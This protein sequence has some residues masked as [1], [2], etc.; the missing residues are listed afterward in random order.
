M[1]DACCENEASLFGA[2]VECRVGEASFHLTRY[3][4]LDP[5]FEV[6][7]WVSEITPNRPVLSMLAY[8][9]AS[10]TNCMKATVLDG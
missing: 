6:G 3:D 4:I 8:W 9:N 5:R 2:N 1:P 7:A 10:V